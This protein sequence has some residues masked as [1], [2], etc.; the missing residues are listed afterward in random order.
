M[1]EKTEVTFDPNAAA[2]MAGKLG[3]FIDL[4]TRAKTVLD[5]AQQAWAQQH[6]W[7]EGERNR[8][9]AEHTEAAK[10]EAAQILA[11]A[12]RDAD[13]IRANA[14]SSAAQLRE[15]VTGDARA[16]LARLTTDIESRS[17]ELG[18][19]QA[20]IAGSTAQLSALTERVTK[21]RASLRGA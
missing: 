18:A 13:T 9:I 8:I 16:H 17:Q 3:S 21:T 20:D 4:F 7:S 2:H 19:I 10:V 12:R 5:A 6:L 14:E 1:T 15:Q 11:D